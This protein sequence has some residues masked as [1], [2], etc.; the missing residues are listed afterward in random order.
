[1]EKVSTLNRLIKVAPLVIAVLL[2]TMLASPVMAN[3]GGHLWFYSEDPESI[4]WTDANKLPNP[5]PDSDDGYVDPNYVSSN[6]DPWLKESIVISSSDW[7]TPFSIW[8][9]C[10]KFESKNTM[11]VVSVN[12]AAFAA[13][14]TIKINGLSLSSWTKATPTQLAPHGV[15]MSDEFHGYAEVPLG[16]LYSPPATPYA[17][18]ITV[19]IT[20]KAGADISGAKIHFDAYG[21]TETGAVITSPYS[22][23][24]TFHVPEAATIIAATSLVGFGIY[25]YKRK[26]Q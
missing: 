10:A 14:D 26:K 15:F 17:V 9:G 24:L 12:E 6:S 19:E 22:H 8:L 20:L 7:E 25:A 16:D 21:Y 5:A 23:D 2:L 18:E 4:V 1:L 13:I 11:L 3:G